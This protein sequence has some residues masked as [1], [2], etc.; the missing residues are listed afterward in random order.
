MIRK[1][2]IVHDNNDESINDNLT[3]DSKS[4]QDQKDIVNTSWSIGTYIRIRPPSKS[5]K[6]LVEYTSEEYTIEYNQKRAVIDL[7]IPPDADPG[8]VHNNVSGRLQ[9]DYDKIFNTNSTQDEVFDIVAKDKILLALEGI[10]LHLNFT[11][12][13]FNH[14]YIYRN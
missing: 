12:H 4:Y 9:F 3:Y 6:G 1:E 13:F 10:F 5:N 8:L 7:D 14:V 2:M 11:F